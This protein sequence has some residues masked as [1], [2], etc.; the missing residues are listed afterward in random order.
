MFPALA[1][2]LGNSSQ[3]ESIFEQFFMSAPSAILVTDGE[4]KITDFNLQAERLLGYSREEIRGQ[5][6][7]LLVPEAERAMHERQRTAYSHSPSVRGLGEKLDLRARKKDGTVIPVDIALS[8]LQLNGELRV[9]A[10]IHDIT[11][12]R[13]AEE[14]LRD[15]AH[16][17]DVLLRE[18][19]HR[20]KNNLAVICSL[21]YLE[22]TYAKDEHA[23]HVFRE[24][25][26]RVHSMALVHESLYGSQNLA[27]INF[28]EYA[29]TLA[30]YILSSF[31]APNNGSVTLQMDQ[32]EAVVMSIE[33]AVPCGLM[34]NEL[35]SNAIKH[36]FP[37]GGKG[38]I[39]IRLQRVSDSYLL[40]IANNGAGIPS[41]MDCQSSH[42]LG[43]R[44][45]RSLSKQLRGSFTLMNSD[46]G[47]TAS[48]EFPISAIHGNG[49]H[50]DAT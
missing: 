41:G 14:K 47:T 27:K 49:G 45:V 19:H 10:A 24:S 32:M 31:G 8:P 43:L 4:G 29:R 7:E 5:P 28:A 33:M 1:K 23:A 9:I 50:S 36:G 26:N 3:S 22:S 16:E 15:S 38:V 21:L 25:E 12:H 2:E 42:S 30:N 39:T 17:K 11:Q 34:L 48:I 46:P 37:N 20:V 35:L 18:V 13:I 40:S 6:V 44:L